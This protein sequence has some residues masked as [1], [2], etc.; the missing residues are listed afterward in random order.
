MISKPNANGNAQVVE[1]VLEALG[2]DETWTPP[3]DRWISDTVVE[4]WHKVSNRAPKDGGTTYKMRTVLDFTGLS[5][6]EI[7]ELAVPAEIVRRQGSFRAMAMSGKDTKG[8]V[9]R[10]GGLTAEDHANHKNAY[11]AATWQAP[12]SLRKIV[13]D[14]RKGGGEDAAKAK[15]AKLIAGLGDAAKAE[16]LAMLQAAAK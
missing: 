8:N 15:A 16:L 14:A 9:V 7:M 3:A 2:K 5:T 6:R 12:V 1:Q 4:V 11:K 13:D 10:K